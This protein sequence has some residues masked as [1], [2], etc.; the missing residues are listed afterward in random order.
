MNVAKKTAAIR[1]LF[2]C[3]F[4]CA[5]SVLSL[6]AKKEKL[7]Q[8]YMA[9]RPLHHNL[10]LTSGVWRFAVQEKRGDQVMVAQVVPAF[11]RSRDWYKNA[12]YFLSDDKSELSV[13]NAGT[14]PDYG[15]RDVWATWLGLT[16][17]SYNA[18][19][20]V[21]PRERQ[22]GVLVTLNQQL[23]A[24]T[25]W[26]W[27]RDWWYQIELPIFQVKR[28][29]R[30]VCSSKIAGQADQLYQ[31][32][33]RP[34]LEYAHL[35]NGPQKRTGVPCVALILGSTY[36]APYG[37]VVTYAAGFE[38]PTESKPEI[39]NL[40]QP[41]LGMRGTGA[42]IADL[43]IDVPLS[44]IARGE[45]RWYIA[46]R[47]R[48]YLSN[49]Q[50]RTFDLRHKPWSRYMLVHKKG[51]ALYI[52]AANVLTQRAKIHPYSFFDMIS[53]F[54]FTSGSFTGE[55]TYGLWAHAKEYIVIRSP[56]VEKIEPDYT[57]YGIMGSDPAYT[58]S[59]STI[60]YKADDDTDKDGHPTFVTIKDT[61][62]DIN[63]GVYRG[64]LGQRAHVA[65]Y[66]RSPDCRGG[67]FA[68]I[69]TFYE[70]P[71]TNA[72]LKN[73]GAWGTVGYEW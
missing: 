30:L 5:V 29:M 7:S 8:L 61:D 64:G 53:G 20:S 50:K 16:D 34:D 49:T 60:V 72:L 4:W 56:C 21:N 40:F 15:G 67:I 38:I 27:L 59:A 63:S 13:T 1:C 71:H 51:S 9:S 46:L 73:W 14:A 32:F 28:D 37:T 18:T 26:D 39:K 12:W 31:A 68:G 54:S 35:I 6:C 41:T 57:Q 17:A 69:G 65:V 36:R 3:V 11:Q 47:N 22:A 48:F 23:C 62:I 52:P 25:S 44:D 55:I 10:A 43:A 19:L 70:W 45:T 2:G 42:V 58:A 66:Y 24:W 33:V